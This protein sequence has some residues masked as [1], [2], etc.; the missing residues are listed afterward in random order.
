MLP[1][2]V[3]SIDRLL[4]LLGTD[5]PFAKQHIAQPVTSIRFEELR[6]GI[7]DVNLVSLYRAKFGDAATRKAMGAVFGKVQVVAGGGFTWPAY[8]NQGLAGRMGI[9]GVPFFLAGRSVALSGAH[10]TETL[11]ELIAAAR[12][13]AEAGADAPA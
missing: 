10:A 13:R 5:T 8:S 9:T 4:Q 12:Q 1:V 6:D 11:A 3:L 7:E 2:V